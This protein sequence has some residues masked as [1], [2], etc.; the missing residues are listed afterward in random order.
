MRAVEESRIVT[1][2]GKPRI[3]AVVRECNA[4]GDSREVNRYERGF[5]E[6]AGE[7]V[8]YRERA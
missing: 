2:I 7:R 1:V 4:A 8:V 3:A 5:E 6:P